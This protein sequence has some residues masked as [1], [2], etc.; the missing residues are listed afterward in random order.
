MG[1]QRN[2]IR[3]ILSQAVDLL[4]FL[5]RTVEHCS[6]SLSALWICT[7]CSSSLPKDYLK[8][9]ILIFFKPQ[10]LTEILS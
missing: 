7:Q 1:K 2:R 8:K 9:V 5:L 6:S 3:W 4:G 10:E